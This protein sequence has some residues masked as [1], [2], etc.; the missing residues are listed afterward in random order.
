MS[1]VAVNTGVG[2]A[3][4]AEFVRAGDNVIISSRTED[5][6]KATVRGLQPLGNGKV[7]GLPTNVAKP[8]DVANL[9]KHAKETLGKVDIWCVAH[10]GHLVRLL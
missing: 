2:K 5:R 3:L 8:V 7:S 6:V 1:D 4:A 10:D 9:A